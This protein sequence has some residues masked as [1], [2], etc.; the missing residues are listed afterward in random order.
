ME[1]EKI[2]KEIKNPLSEIPDDEISD[3]LNRRLWVLLKKSEDQADEEA[4]NL[5]GGDLSPKFEALDS[6][7][8]SGIKN[9]CL[10]FA[11]CAEIGQQKAR[12]SKTEETHLESCRFCERR[13][14]K[15]GEVPAFVPIETAA[16][17]E[18]TIVS[19]VEK[20]RWTDIF[21]KLGKFSFF[22][23]F[24]RRLVLAG[25]ALIVLSVAAIVVF[26]YNFSD[27]NEKIAVITDSGQ[28]VPRIIDPTVSETPAPAPQNE[29]S[30]NSGDGNSITSPNNNKETN[31]NNKTPDRLPAGDLEEYSAA[32]AFL[33]NSEREA[34][35]QSIEVG[36][37]EISENIAEFNEASLDRRGSEN[38]EGFV[39]QIE[40]RNESTLEPRPVVRWQSSE[41]SEYRVAILDR[42][43]NK[44]AE[45][46]VLTGNS[47]QP[48]KNLPAGFYFW[49]IVVR[50]KGANVFESTENTVFFK[51]V[52]AAEKA[53][54]ERA[55][56][57]TNSNL[58]TAVLYARAGLFAEA[59][60]EL[61]IELRKNPKSVK[62]QRML[63]Q[64]RRWKSK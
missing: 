33:P 37:I 22:D 27:P 3:E 40:P 52:G 10:S 34:V 59:E 7:E 4:V 39:R 24:S 5:G 35:R 8:K 14:E 36:R 29:N 49:E 58:V 43:M 26:R 15:F 42:G 16:Q 64:I 1:N 9:Q 63:A 48:E 18:S 54:I 30:G 11:R 28:N 20:P 23:L 46:G 44:I 45:S 47:W 41:G 6:L 50:K 61:N 60:R 12:L 56:K 13:I 17:T 57:A 53:R 31:A 55:K 62:A 19:P 21:S 2:N 38:E 51:I 32:L 25:L